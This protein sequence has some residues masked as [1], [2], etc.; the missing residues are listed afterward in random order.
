MPRTP[1]FGSRRNSSSRSRVPHKR[2]D[3]LATLCFVF[4]VL[5]VPA[6]APRAVAAP[7]WIYRGIV[8]PR[9]VVAMD[10]GVGV[11]H[12][13]TAANT[14]DTGAG[15][16]VEIS[17]G[18]T[19]EGELG[20]RAGFRL[21]D[22]GQRLQADRYGRPFQTETYGGRTDRTARWLPESGLGR[23]LLRIRTL[24]APLFGKRC[25]STWE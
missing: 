20:V 17:G 21:D 5:G 12:A 24:Y 3:R 8:L 15:L 16:N 13:P 23:L 9:G 10:F 1:T 18:L 6:G 14:S 25:R 11:A 4:G 2:V 19:N 7:A 22:A